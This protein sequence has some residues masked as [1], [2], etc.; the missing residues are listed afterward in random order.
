MARR[1]KLLRFVSLGC[2]S[3]ILLLM[4]IGL[5]LAIQIRAMNAPMTLTG[6]HPFRSQAKKE[7]YLAYYDARAERWRRPTRP[8]GSRS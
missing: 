5:W 8:C 7:Q 2:A 3:V 4:G 1:R 6:Y